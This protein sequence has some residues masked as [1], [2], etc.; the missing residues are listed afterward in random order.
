MAMGD[1]VIIP[2]NRQYFHD[3]INNEQKKCDRADGVLD[4]SMDFTKDKVNNLLSTAALYSKLDELQ[5]WIEST[6]SSNNEKIRALGYLENTLQKYRIAWKAK[7]IEGSDFSALI[8]SL[9]SFI[10]MSDQDKN[11][12]EFISEKSYETAKILTE[13]FYENAGIEEAKKKGVYKILPPAP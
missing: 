12:S 3:K 13:V 10:K 11:I 8:S 1:T 4:G 9:E 7:S 2:L 5:D 6:D